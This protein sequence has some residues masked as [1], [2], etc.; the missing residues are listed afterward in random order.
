MGL[1]VTTSVARAGIPQ[2]MGALIAAGTSICGV[3]AITALSPAIKA[4][5]RDTAVAVANVVA[6][7]TFGMLTYRTFV[8]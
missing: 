1:L 6:F 2:K 8:P 4:S 5:P 7:G 3:T